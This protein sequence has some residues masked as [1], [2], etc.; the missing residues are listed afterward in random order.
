MTSLTAWV[1]DSD[2]M[3]IIGRAARAF[4]KKLQYI[5]FVWPLLCAL[6]LNQHKDL[7]LNL[8]ED[9]S[10]GKDHNTNVYI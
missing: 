1:P 6:D 9:L 4:R 8:S 10:L 3:V 7:N 2:S 5:T